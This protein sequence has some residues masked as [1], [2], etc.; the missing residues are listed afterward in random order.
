M[1]HLKTLPVDIRNIVMITKVAK[2]YV[3]QITIKMCLL[4]KIMHVTASQMLHR[5]SSIQLQMTT[6]V[7]LRL[8]GTSSV[9]INGHKMNLSA[10]AFPWDLGAIRPHIRTRF[11]HPQVII[12]NVYL[13]IYIE[14]KK[15]IFYRVLTVEQGFLIQTSSS[16]MPR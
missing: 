9:Y 5:Y 11:P 14:R 8:P 10:E 2:K 3:C 6:F 16:S 15:R 7:T 12:Y 13:M 4:Q 1:W